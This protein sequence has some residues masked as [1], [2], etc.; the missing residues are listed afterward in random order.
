MR[1][2]EALKVLRIVPDTELAL[3]AYVLLLLLLLG[4]F[5]TVV[6]SR[7]SGAKLSGFK[8]YLCLLLAV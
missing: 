4:Q 3:D 7:D 6:K 5:G 2:N 8:S 1:I